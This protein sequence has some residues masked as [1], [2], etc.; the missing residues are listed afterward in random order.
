[1]LGVIVTAALLTLPIS[2]SVFIPQKEAKPIHISQHQTTSPAIVR[3]KNHKILPLPGGLN[4]IPVFN[5]N[6]PELVLG[7]GILLSTFPPDDKKDKSAHLNYAFEGRFDVFAHHVAKPVNEEDTRTLYLGIIAHNPTNKTVTVDILAGASYL[8]QPDAPFVNLP[9]VVENRNTYAGPGSRVMGEILQGKRQDIFPPRI[10]IPPGESRMLLNLPIPVQNLTPKLNGRSTYLQLYSDGKLYLASLAMY[11][12]EEDNPPSLSQ[13]EE[14]LKNGTLSTPR[15]L[16]PTPPNQ[17]SGRIIYGRVAG[18][19]LGNMWKSTVT[20]SPNSLY[21]TI[22]EP[23]EAL[24]YGLSTLVG[25]TLGTN[26]IQTASLLVRYPDT[27]H[28]AHGN[29]GVRYSLTLPLFNPTNEAKRVGIAIST[30]LKTD[31][32]DI[33]FFDNPPSQVFFRGL[34]QVRYNDDDNIPRWRYFHLV[35]YRGQKG[36]DLVTV[37]IPPNS[38]RLVLVDFLYPPDATPP[39]I[40]TLT[41]YQP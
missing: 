3:E 25:G 24:S 2:M 37:T 15:D 38:Q 11:Q 5:S 7:E 34:V 23:G 9:S 1:M 28:S 21:L 30:P 26:Q 27:A 10:E 18:V 22:P 8:S 13:W 40:L 17:N 41:T 4:N 19:S 6:S 35:Q 31:A 39:Q 12:Q 16:P 36:Q 32:A 20:D 14:L 29:Y 33:S